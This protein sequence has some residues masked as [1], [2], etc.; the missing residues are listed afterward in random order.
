LAIDHGTNRSGWSVFQD[1]LY[2]ES[3]IWDYSKV[4]HPQVLLAFKK[5]IL[6]KVA[7]Y[8]CDLL[9]YEVQVSVVN[10]RSTEVLYHMNAVE[11]LT[12]LEQGLP[13]HG[14]NNSEW[15]KL[16]GYPRSEKLEIAYALSERFDLDVDKIAVPIRYTKDTRKAKK[17]EVREY[18]CDESDALGLNFAYWCS[19]LGDKYRRD[20]RGY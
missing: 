1:G 2:R 7:D 19:V 9:L 17:G 8:K 16:M 18:L 4:E 15:K 11:I 12:A 3:G 13:F 10:A 14:Y 5:D 20:T 6:L